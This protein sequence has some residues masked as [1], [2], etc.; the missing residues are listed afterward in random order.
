MKKLFYS[1]LGLIC[2]TF[3]SCEHDKDSNSFS[4]ASDLEGIWVN[5]DMDCQYSY[6]I[7]GNKIIYREHCSSGWDVHCS[8]G[9]IDEENYFVCDDAEQWNLGGHLTAKYEFDEE[10]Q[11]IYIGGLKICTLARLGE[12]KVYCAAEPGL[13]QLT[14]S[15]G[16]LQRVVGVKKAP[17]P[18]IIAYTNPDQINLDN[19]DSSVAESC[20]AV[21]TYSGTASTTEY[22]WT[23]EY[24][25]AAGVKLALEVAQAAGADVAYSWTAAAASDEAD[26]EAKNVQ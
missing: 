4:S 9:Y 24:W 20:W 8:G 16:I 3:I 10:E 2:L 6:E 26:C 21:T 15:T 5:V 1:L 7:Q 18:T 25:L 11:T 22:I 13:M 23:N 19:Y 12:D 17:A 14:M